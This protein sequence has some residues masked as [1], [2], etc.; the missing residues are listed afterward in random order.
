[1]RAQ[2][3]LNASNRPLTALL[4]LLILLV[5]AQSA[6]AKKPEDPDELF[7]PF[8]GPEFAHWLVGPIV[9]L[10]TEKEVEDYLLLTTDTEAQA[11]REAFWA[12]RNEGTKVFT[13]NPQQIFEERA[14]EADKRYTEGTYPGRRTDRG[15][16]LIVYGEPK[17]ITFESPR[18]VGD[19]PLEVWR[20]DRD[21]KGLDTKKPK[22][23]YRFVDLGETV[24]RYTGQRLPA[25]FERRLRQRRRF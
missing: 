21:E 2:Q 8:L 3:F 11:F 10:A 1:M 4:A 16:I 6:G 17:E 23:M 25:D 5:A 7:N 15:T 18:K 9:E 13:K 14:L 19:P 12:K 22:K 20:Y 24:I